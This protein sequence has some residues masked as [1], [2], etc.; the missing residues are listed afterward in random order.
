MNP[1]IQVAIWMLPLEIIS[2]C[3]ACEL[4]RRSKLVHCILMFIVPACLTPYWLLSIIEKNDWFAISKV[5][6]VTCFGGVGIYVHRW[7]LNVDLKAKWTKE[8]FHWWRRLESIFAYCT[9]FV[10]VLEAVLQDASQ[11]R[12]VNVVTGILLALAQTCD[13]EL[14]QPS[15]EGPIYDGLWISFFFFFLCVCIR[16]SGTNDPQDS[17]HDHIYPVAYVLWN[18]TFC[19]GSYGHL[20]VIHLAAPFLLSWRNGWNLFMMYRGYALAFCF[21]VLFSHKNGSSWF[22]WDKKTYYGLYYNHTYY[23]CL[24]WIALNYVIFGLLLHQLRLYREDT[25]RGHEKRVSSLFQ[26]ILYAIGVPRK[27]K[28]E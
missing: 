5:Y 3:V 10:N 4:A 25:Q 8:R 28:K 15:P 20:G 16:I 1:V 17:V 2:S 19:Y 14:H 18:H 26:W 12:Y 9:L 23:S 22:F 6:S 27:S 24:Q 13:Q 7:V 21:Q 11:H